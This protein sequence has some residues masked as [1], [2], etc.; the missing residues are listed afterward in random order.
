M[1]LVMLRTIAWLTE[2]LSQFSAMLYLQKKYGQK[3]LEEIQKR[4][5]RWV[6]KKSDLGPIILGPRLSYLD[7]AGYQA[8]VYDKA[9]L[10]LFMLKDLHGRGCLF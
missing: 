1:A 3:E 4:I 5:S 8:I 10:V 6:R 9:A 2:G 7:F